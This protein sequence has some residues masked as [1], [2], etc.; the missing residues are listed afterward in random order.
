MIRREFIKQ[1]I[2]AGFALAVMPTTAW[3]ILTSSEDL[4]TDHVNIPTPKGMM[5][6]YLAMPKGSGPFPTVLVI[7]EIFGVHAYIQD[8][9]H[10]LAKEGYLAIAPYLYFREGDVT[11]MEDIQQIISKVVNKTNPSQ[12]MSDLDA[13]VE[14]LSKNKS[15]NSSMLMMTGFCWGGNIVWTYSYHQPKIKTGVAWYGKLAS[16]PGSESSKT[17]IEIARTLKTPILG[18]YGGKDQGIPLKDV[19]KMRSALKE[20]RSGSEILVFPEAEH[21]FHADYRPSYNEKSA[22]EGWVKML[23]WFKKHAHG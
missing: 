9:C 23:D 16:S 3:A 11:Q 14:W 7:H 17:P 4:V 21:G 22:K 15:A 12:V 10:R 1:G 18:L 20:G 5:P 13:A 19:Q 6:A 8:V 2:S